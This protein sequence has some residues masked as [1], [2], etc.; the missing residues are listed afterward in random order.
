[1]K[2]TAPAST[3]GTTCWR[4]AMSLEQALALILAAHA[5][6][7]AV[8]FHDLES[9]QR[10]ELKARERMHAASTMKLAVLLAARRL[11]VDPEQKVRIENRFR[12]IVD[13][14]EFSVDQ[15]DDDDPW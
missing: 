5:Q 2:G 12:S 13:G 9:G 11:K 4:S 1:A 15:R 7:I 3:P 10:V 6:T 8:A 14:S